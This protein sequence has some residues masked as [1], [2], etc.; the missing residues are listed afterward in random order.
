MPVLFRLRFAVLNLLVP[1]LA[2][3]LLVQ[4]LDYS[5]Y[6]HPLLDSKASLLYGP[7][8]LTLK[9][10]GTAAGI[11]EPLVAVGKPG[12]ATL[13]YVRLLKDAHAKVGIEFWGF[14]AWESSAFAVPSQDARIKVDISF[15]ALFPARDSS[16]WGWV[17]DTK[18]QYLL[19]HFSIAV[20]H[21]V[22]VNGTTPYVMPPDSPT[23]IGLN[24][25]GG[26]FVSSAFTGTVLSS[27]R[28]F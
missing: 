1:L 15:P 5:F 16:A 9:L 13:V 8:S 26:S 18:K 7:L 27:S 6:P 3:W 2:S 28:T 14:K 20:N 19:T 25:L 4:L 12:V 24:P 11:E 23:Y 22:Q 17:S 21:V 10:P